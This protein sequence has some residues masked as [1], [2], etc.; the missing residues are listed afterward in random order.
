MIITPVLPS[1]LMKVSFSGMWPNSSD[2]P[3]DSARSSFE[4]A[5]L[6]AVLG[7]LVEHPEQR[8]EDRHLHQDRQA[9][10]ER[11]GARLAVERHRL[12]GE[13][14]AVVAVLLLQL[15]DPGL[16]QLHV[17]AGLDL[18]DEQRD[19]RRP[20]HERQA[21]DRQRPGEAAVGVDADRG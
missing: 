14:L 4:E 18:L 11:V 12:L 10:R 3:N 16:D 7:G 2:W 6:L 13:P 19:Q 15:L 5:V 21:D 17:A 20:H 8:Q 1:L 9:G